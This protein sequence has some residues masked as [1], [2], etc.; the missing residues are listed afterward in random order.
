MRDETLRRWYGRL[1]RLYPASHRERFAEAMEQTFH[2]L[3]RERGGQ[4][5]IWLFAET[6]RSIVLEH[7]RH[8]MLEPRQV[9]RVA[10]VTAA[11]LL[12][13][14]VAMRFTDDVVWTALDF[15]VA[16]T[17][18]FGAGLAFEWVASRAPNLPAK[19]GAA[20]AVATALF[21]VWANL[22]VGLIGS[23]DEPVNLLYVG[24]LAVAGVGALLARFRPSGMARAMFAAALGQAAVAA[25]ALA[26]GMDR[27]PGSS[28][29]EIVNV[30]AVFAAS[31]VGSGVLFLRG[32][33]VRLA[34][35]GAVRD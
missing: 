4:S 19:A 11:L 28:V 8:A 15:S 14:A 1:L 12:V 31:W 10:A 21:L 22:A 27:L 20:A 6:F 35:D 17:L 9:L 18:L 13:P 7:V 25:I 33:R 26:A 16:G 30:N 3:L 24:V 29:A 32:A 34:V 23:E 5:V 2:D